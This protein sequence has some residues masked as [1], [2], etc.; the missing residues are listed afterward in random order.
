MIS[1]RNWQLSEF[2]FKFRC[3]LRNAISA[4]STNVVDHAQLATEGQSM[5]S[6]PNQS[7][8]EAVNEVLIAPRAAHSGYC[9]IVAPSGSGKTYLYNTL[10]SIAVGG[11]RRIVRVE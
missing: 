10:F 7:Q 4:M 9:F 3:D 2:R 6:S 8:R 1:Q 11:T 5:Y